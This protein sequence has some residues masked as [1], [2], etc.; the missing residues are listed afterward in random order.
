[1]YLTLLYWFADFFPELG[2]F[3]DFL[4]ISLISSVV[5]DKEIGGRWGAK[6]FKKMILCSAG[7]LS[8][9]K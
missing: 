6:N 4:V 1:M 8:A 5:T 7:A 9:A 3:V 2:F